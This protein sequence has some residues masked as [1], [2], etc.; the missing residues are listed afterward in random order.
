MND[1]YVSNRRRDILRLL[2]KEGDYSLSNGNIKLLLKSVFAYAVNKDEVAEDLFFLEAQALI[3]LQKDIAELTEAGSEVV[4]GD[5][6][7]EG[8]ARKPFSQGV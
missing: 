2:Y 6:V 4:L 5:R 8:V 1:I 7:I 3:S